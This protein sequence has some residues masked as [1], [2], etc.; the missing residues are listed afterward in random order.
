ISLLINGRYVRHLGL[1]QAILR[2]YHTLLP[3]H[4][5]PIAVLSIEMDPSLL[6]VNVHPAK[7]EVR[8]SKEQELITFVEEQVGLVLRKQR[9]IPEPTRQSNHPSTVQTNLNIAE[10]LSPDHYRTWT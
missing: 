8:F 4:R 3:I 1:T 9:L 7:L 10:T 6:D 5:Y 2:G